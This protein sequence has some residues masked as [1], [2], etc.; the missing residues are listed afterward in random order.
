MPKIV[1]IKLSQVKYKGKA[2]GDD[3]HIRIRYLN[4]FLNID[5]KMKHGSEII[6]NQ[7]IGETFVDQ[8]FLTQL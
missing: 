5:K 6:L 4:F 7:K 2:I 8:I 1:K 3:I